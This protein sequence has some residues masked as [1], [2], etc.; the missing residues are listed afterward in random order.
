MSPISLKMRIFL[1]L[2]ST[3]NLVGC[4][5]AIGGL[6]LFFADVITEW[7]L[8]IVA[9]LYAVGWLAVPGDKE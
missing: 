7:W 9:G 8:P 1:F 4:A 3:Q 6:G 2:Y 5:L